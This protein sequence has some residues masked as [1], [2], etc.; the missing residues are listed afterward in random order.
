VKRALL[1]TLSFAPVLCWGQLFAQKWTVDHQLSTFGTHAGAS[2]CLPDGTIAVVA[3]QTRP[4]FQE[5]LVVRGYTKDGA[6]AWTYNYIDNNLDGS[7]PGEPIVK[8]D[9]LGHIYVLTGVRP[10]GDAP[11]VLLLKFNKTGH[12][13]ARHLDFSA[14]S[15]DERGNIALDSSGN[16]VI[17]MWSSARIGVAR[18]TKDGQLLYRSANGG[19]INGTGLGTPAK[20]HIAYDADRNVI[21][22]GQYREDLVVFKLG[23]TGLRLWTRVL[24]NTP[25]YK[26]I[27]VANLL[28]DGSM[29]LHAKWHTF[30]EVIKV[31]SNG[32]IAWRKSGPTD[33]FA[34]VLQ[35]GGNWVIFGNHWNN[36]QLIYR[37]TSYTPS[38]TIAWTKSFSLPAGATELWEQDRPRIIASLDAFDDIYLSIP[39][40]VDEMNDDAQYYTVKMTSYGAI[41]WTHLY[42]PSGT[43]NRVASNVVNPVTGDLFVLGETTLRGSDAIKAICYRQA[44][45]PTKETYSL[46]RNTTLSPLKSVLWNDRYAAEATVTVAVPPSHGTVQ[47]NSG[48]YFS[49]TPN[50]GYVGPDS[51]TYRAS[52]PGVTA[53]QAVVTLNVQ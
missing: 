13:W 50:A 38:G 4:D 42:N 25:G 46:P 22:A 17:V 41:R 27:E 51:F 12:L 49:Y 43:L 6:I 53:G 10:P 5:E 33:C 40:L 48:G 39:T 45:Q 28:S 9:K 3:H 1:L 30:S 16:P 18:Y 24:G 52:K 37:A 21:V 20:Q 32:T 44:V 35:K 7:T 31:N 14:G 19:V 23:S 47:M 34:S 29:I 2:A 15:R 11:D 8:V 36:N 26:A